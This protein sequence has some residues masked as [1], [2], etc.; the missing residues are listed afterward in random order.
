MDRALRAMLAAIAAEPLLARDY[1]L[2]GGLALRLLFGGPRRSDDLDLTSAR[3]FTHEVTDE[4]NEMLLAFCELLDASLEEVQAA[5][6]LR[7]MRVLEKTLS[8]EIPALLGSVAYR[9]AQSSA[10]G[11]YEAKM[12]ITLSEFICETAR[13][14]VDGI[15]IHSATLEDILADKLKAL[16]QQVTRNKLR[17]MDVYDV[18]YFGTAS[19]HVLQ[20]DRLREYLEI[21]AARWPEVFPPTPNRFHDPELREYS[22]QRFE[23]FVRDLNPDAPRVS[24]DD[25][26]SGVLT[27]VDRLELPHLMVEKGD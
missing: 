1:V 15:V 8:A 5:Y 11:P 22:A 4:K 26:F 9:D 2:K 18:W 7:E 25:A 17:P 24:F 10:E 21:K 3:P 13:H 16:L 12:Q 19:D 6:E 20:L 23:A 14:T 27:L